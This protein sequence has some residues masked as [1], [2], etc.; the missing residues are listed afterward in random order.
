MAGTRLDVCVIGAGPRGL[1]VVERLCANA[2]QFPTYETVTVHVVDPY[3]PG[4]GQVWR[5]DQ[6]RHLLM[7]TVA[8][9][10]TV[11]TDESV[12][13]AGPLAPG[14]SLH[15]WARAVAGDPAYDAA[16]RA[17]AAA[18]GPDA[19]PTRA[20]YGDYLSWA[21]GRVVANAPARVRVRVHAA[22]AV[23][24]DDTDDGTGSGAGTQ[25]VTLEGGQRLERLHA[26]VLAQGHVPV[27]ASPTQSRLADFAARHDLV[28]VPP[29]NPADADL[30]G[31][32]PGEPVLLRGLGL[33]FFDHMALLTEGRGGRYERRAGR[34][35]YLPSGR[36]PR[37]Y[38]GSR[39]GMPYHSRGE[40][41]KGVE[42]RHEPFLLT[43]ELVAKLRAQA[44]DT[45]GL[46]FRT[47]LWPLVAREVETVYY[48]ALLTAR[49]QA[50]RVPAFRERYLAHAADGWR[51]GVPASGPDGAGD[52]PA[53][54]GEADAEVLAAF[55]IEV[56]DRWDW[57][58]IERPY[59]QREFADTEEFHAWLL[60]HL[61]Q[62]LRAARE[63]NV[64]GPLKAALDV[65][66]D[67]RNELRLA[68]DHGGL[69]GDSYR[70]DLDRWYTPLNAYLSIGPPARRVEELVALI[71][72]GTVRVAGPAL[73][74][75]PDPRAGAY[76]ARSSAVPGSQVSA[77]VLIEARLPET[78]LRRTADPLLRHLLATGQCA[79]YRMPATDGGSHESGGLA[80]TERPYRLLD[81]HGVAHPR[82]FAFGVPTEAVHWVTAA[83][84]R[85]G[86]DSVI[87]GDSDAIARAVLGALDHDAGGSAARRRSDGAGVAPTSG[88]SAPG[89][90]RWQDVVMA[91]GGQ[92]PQD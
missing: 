33:N 73:E 30:S 54:A 41:E 56:A 13:M 16:V 87:L 22:R 71:E 69:S 7:N 82:R 43:P 10:V 75:A 44:A 64:S 24:L 67:L 77:R 48:G 11:F 27:E 92:E 90:D 80:V 45:P 50:D 62:D 26:V 17:E 65:L 79:P 40:N 23:A 84:I 53:G 37:L 28:Y 78:D 20:L 81:A 58:A 59:G 9:Q 86:V 31:V 83:G 8:C 47:T 15:T 70:D 55:G 74:I 49:G 29:G 4:P 18:L 60:D 51:D 39:R 6:S 25:T 85:P 89:P 63:G 66:R 21:F 5:T 57:A 3:A 72:A 1:S 52:D 2:R 34:L 19:Y 42:G 14:P 91:P 88:P 36:E 32:R 38:A 76:V 68:V 12:A 46:S 35:T 61:R